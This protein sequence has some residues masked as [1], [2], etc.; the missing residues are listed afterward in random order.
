[1]LFRLRY[2]MFIFYFSTVYNCKII[3]YAPPAFMVDFTARKSLVGK[4]MLKVYGLLLFSLLLTVGVALL[5]KHHAAHPMLPQKIETV[6]GSCQLIANRSML[7]A[8]VKF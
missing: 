7:I 5:G 3:K 2:Q 1:M 4:A 8:C 6:S